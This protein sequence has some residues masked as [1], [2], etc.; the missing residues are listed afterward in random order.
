M[1]ILFDPLSDINDQKFVNK[2]FKNSDQKSERISCPF[3]FILLSCQLNKYYV[4]RDIVG[5][6]T[7]SAR[8]VEICEKEAYFVKESDKWYR[9]LKENDETIKN[10][11]DLILVVNCAGCKKK[12]GE[13]HHSKGYYYF[14][15]NDVI[16]GK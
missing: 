4:K 6:F 15:A 16:E 11:P 13:Y 9:N 1:E 12:V 2:K 7:K 8:N 3:C 5:Y 14:G 10:Q